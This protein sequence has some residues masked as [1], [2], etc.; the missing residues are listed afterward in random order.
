[1]TALVT[2][3]GGFLGK[4]VVE[5]LLQRGETVRSFSRRDYP[6]LRAR[7]AE[8]VRGDL[9][10]A[11]T[12]K[13]ACCG[14]DIVFHVAAKAGL[15]G[16]YAEFFRT[17]VKGTEN[18]I[19]GCRATGISRLVYTSSPSVVFD[20]KDMEG[21]DET[22]PYPVTFKS[23]YPATKAQAEQLVL[24]ANGPDLATVALRPHLIWGPGDT[25][26]TAGILERARMGRV[27]RLGNQA[28]RVDF[29]YVSNAALA[30]LLAADR[31]APGG[32]IAGRAYFI[33]NGEPMELWDFINRLLATA[34]LPPIDRTA[35]IWLA[36]LAGWLSETLW[37]TLRLRGEPPL[38]RFL[39]EE[40]STAH[41]FNI[42]AARR[43][44]GYSPEV[45]LEEGF[46]RLRQ[47]GV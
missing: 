17:N 29:T 11:E 24:R 4:A 38:T 7:G 40:L 3:G 41:W 12:I 42:E 19:A 27:R 23:P 2:G 32:R 1:M 9:A 30:H 47:V 15:W 44:L 5:M 22:A 14:C 46:E 43:D 28:K 34:G 33:T 25:N 18:V 6:E 37:R 31:L 20:G 39:A 13:E 8:I 45:T 35:P 21:A 16:D 26:L 36:Y 10:E